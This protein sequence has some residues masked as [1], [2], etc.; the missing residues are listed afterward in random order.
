M[1]LLPAIL[2]L[3]AI[4]SE[5]VAIVVHLWLHHTSHAASAHLIA[6]HVLALWTA[7]SAHVSTLVPT[8]HLVTVATRG[9]LS[10][11]RSWWLALLILIAWVSLEVCIAQLDRFVQQLCPLHGVDSMLGLLF[12]TEAK[13][14]ESL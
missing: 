2:I 8:L 9:V 11:S 14:A 12:D 5:L 13:E 1:P 4:A 6:V 7:T 3:H 10:E